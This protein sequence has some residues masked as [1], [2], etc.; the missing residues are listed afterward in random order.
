MVSPGAEPR[1]LSHLLQSS[2]VS[3]WD[4][5]RWPVLAAVSNAAG[6]DDRIVWARGFGVSP[7][8]RASGNI[9]EAL[10]VFEFDEAGRDWTGAESW[11]TISAAL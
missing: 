11:E 6:L 2:A 9:R 10:R 3:S 1:S 5:A 4:R 8:L 7:E